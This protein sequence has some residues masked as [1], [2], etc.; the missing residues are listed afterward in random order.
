[1]THKTISAQV[2]H[3]HLQHEESLG[4]L[5]GQHVLAMLTVVPSTSARED[6]VESSTNNLGEDLDLDPSTLA[7][8]DIENDIYFPI[9]P[10]EILLEKVE[11]KIEPGQPCIILPEELPDD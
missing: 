1:M 8:L 6:Q 3:G 5:E 10:P 7:W 4:E 2:I 9:V 11:I